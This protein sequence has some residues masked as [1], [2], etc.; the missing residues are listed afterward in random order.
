MPSP[1]PHSSPH[2]KEMPLLVGNLKFSMD[3]DWFLGCL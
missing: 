2:G 3:P 1:E